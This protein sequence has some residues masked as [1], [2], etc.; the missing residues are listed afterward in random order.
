MHLVSMGSP[1]LLRFSFSLTMQ[2][3]GIQQWL[4]DIAGLQGNHYSEKMDGSSPRSSIPGPPSSASR[5]WSL[6]RQTG[7]NCSVFARAMSSSASGVSLRTCACVASGGS[8]RRICEVLYSD[9]GS[10]SRLIRSMN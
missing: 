3:L 2:R 5:C 6:P 7:R 9:S 8:A 4:A 10:G 1:W